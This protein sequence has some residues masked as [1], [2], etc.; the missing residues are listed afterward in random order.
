MNR[1]I[2]SL[3]HGRQQQQQQQQQQG[4]STFQRIAELPKD[5]LPLQEH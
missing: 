1:P 4:S 5:S 2:L 3:D